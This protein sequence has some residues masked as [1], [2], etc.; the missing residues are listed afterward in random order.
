[1]G[2]RTFND[3]FGTL[4]VDLLLGCVGRQDTVE[5]VRF[6]LLQTNS[7]TNNER[8]Q[9]PRTLPGHG[10]GTDNTE[11]DVTQVL[12]GSAP[13]WRGGGMSSDMASVVTRQRK[14]H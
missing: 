13:D 4:V 1:M 10:S 5:H 14:K 12:E 7:T 11:S 6:P 3:L 2:V 8:W 9:F